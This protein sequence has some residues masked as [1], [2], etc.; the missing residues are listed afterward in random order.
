MPVSYGQVVGVANPNQG[1]VDVPLIVS[2][3]VS[4]SGT[5]DVNII[6]STPVVS[7]T[8]VRSPSIDGVFVF[9]TGNLPGVVAANNYLSLFNPVGSGKVLSFG[10]AFISCVAATGSTVTDPMQGFRI[11]AAS[12]GTLQAAN[13]IAKFVTS[14]AAP[15]AEIRVGNPTVTTGAQLFNSPPAISATTGSTNVHVIPVPGGLAPF[16]LVEGEGIVLRTAVGDTDQRWNLSIVW[17]EI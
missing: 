13:T 6:S 9:S 15:V 12:A 17:S 14:D 2:G 1:G 4:S 10:S 5:Q 16:T 11:T 3:T 8:S 7:T